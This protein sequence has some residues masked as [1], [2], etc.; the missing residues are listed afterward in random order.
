MVCQPQSDDTTEND[1]GAG[2][3]EPSYRG[4]PGRFGRVGL[5]EVRP[6][7][8]YEKSCRGEP[9]ND[10]ESPRHLLRIAR[11]RAGSTEALRAFRGG[12]RSLIRERRLRI[13][14]APALDR[15]AMRER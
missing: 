13:S 12:S 10:F 1:Q 4:T 6:Y 3:E 14:T 7:Q 8:D 9:G 15:L 2:V 11:V 5:K